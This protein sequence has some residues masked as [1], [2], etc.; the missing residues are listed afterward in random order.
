MMSDLQAKC[1][2]ACGDRLKLGAK[3]QVYGQ[4]RQ[5]RRDSKNNQISNEKPMMAPCSHSNLHIHPHRV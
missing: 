2:C 4:N 3:Y 1:A 5:A